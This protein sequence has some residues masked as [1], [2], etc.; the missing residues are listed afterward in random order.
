MTEGSKRL[1]DWAVELQ[2]LAQ[3]G[4][5]YGRD[6]YDIE[7][8]QRIR[9]ISAEMMAH[10]SDLPVEKVRDLFC[11]ESGYQTPKLDTR[12]AIFGI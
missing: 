7:R 1:L 12:A 2:S 6:V 4:L 11:N 10:L 5:A 8:F 3:A 9:E